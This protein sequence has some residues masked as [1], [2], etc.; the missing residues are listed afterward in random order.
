MKILVLGSDGQLGKCFKDQFKHFKANL[1]YAT[2]AEINIADFHST[3][4]KIHQ[5]QPDVIINAAAYTKVD[6]AESDK[7]L[8]N[9]INHLAVE[10]IAKICHNIKSWL[11]HISTDYVF[12]GDHKDPYTEK[13]ATNP[14]S[15]YGHTKL[16]GEKA[17]KRSNC[18]YI[19]IRTAWVYSEHG[20]NFLKTILK[21]GL[22]NNQL[23]I[24]G[25][26][27]GCPTYAQDIAKCIKGFIKKI[28]LEKLNSGLY[29]FSGD[30][31]CSWAEFSEHIFREAFNLRIINYLPKVVH[32]TT[33]EF[34]TKAKRP[35]NSVLNSNK[36]KDF[37]K[38]DSSNCIN[39]IK[40][41]LQKIKLN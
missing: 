29:H 36:I 23:P 18:Q 12:D 32:I 27:F 9:L 11:I 28:E 1:Y 20:N 4:L 33:D 38:I 13:D 6:D 40:S 14:M 7:E 3:K 41:T 34:P 15:I 22:K 16:E 2:K 21:L 31:A 39:G 26:Q 30:L 10:N 8:A 25:D 5:I 19:L 24:V 17:I 37:L 35:K